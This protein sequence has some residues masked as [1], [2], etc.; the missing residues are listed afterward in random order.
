M[1][2]RRAKMGDAV[3]R[4]SWRSSFLGAPGAE[5]F[6]ESGG[7][8]V[9]RM[10]S[11]S[12]APKF[13]GQGPLPKIP[14][15]SRRQEGNVSY[16]RCAQRICLAE[17]AV[18]FFE[19]KNENKQED[20]GCRGLPLWGRGRYRPLPQSLYSARRYKNAFVKAEAGSKKFVPP[21]GFTSLISVQLPSN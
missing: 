19:K 4:A 5:F 18:G 15:L 8:L 13:P 2:P 21:K 20:A 16:C 1:R 12:G 17:G 3:G 7:S 11:T 9:R 10:R 6:A 14:C